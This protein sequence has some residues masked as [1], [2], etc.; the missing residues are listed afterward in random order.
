MTE[1]KLETL[2]QIIRDYQGVAVAFS[3]G[4]DSSLLLTLCVEVLGR[5]RVVALI[6]SSPT[7]PVRE[8]ERAVAFCDSLNVDYQILQTDEMEDEMYRQNSPLRCY[9]CKSHLFGEALRYAGERG[10]SIIVEGSNADDV[11][12]YRPGRKATVELGV[13]SPLLEAGLTKGEIRQISRQLGLVTS[14]LPAKACLASRIPYD[15]PIDEAVLERIDLAEEYLES[16]GLGQV[17]VRYHGDVARIEVDPDKFPRVIEYREVIA[18]RLKAVGFTY[19][20]LDLVGYRTGSLNEIL[21]NV[22]E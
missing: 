3:G 14:D 6:G 20:V 5:E 19:V 16:L 13:K 7:Y 10:F 18:T 15:T 11:G 4:V 9:Y 22:S 2:K 21:V 17:R 8:R 12:D 1:Q